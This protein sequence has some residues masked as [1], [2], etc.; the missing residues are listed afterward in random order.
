MILKGFKE[1]SI[2]KYLNK[3]L[4][5]RKIYVD[6]SKVESLGVILNIDE[7]EDFELFRNLATFLR[8]RPN[9]FKI[10]AYSPTKSEKPNFWE[11]CFNSRDIGWYGSIKKIELQSFLDRPFDALISYY[12]SDEVEL[13][14]LTG[15]SKAQFKI[16]ILQKDE[17]LN[18]LIIKTNKEEFE[19][20]K[21]EIFKYL[22]I[23]NKL[24]NE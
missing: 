13:R 16:G 5:E 10:I 14:L 22:T 11:V 4:S 12:T 20:F 7:V 24:N 15:L 17:R 21:K 2:K 8:V 18:D 1:K 6:D 9:K 19:V 23:L 3:I